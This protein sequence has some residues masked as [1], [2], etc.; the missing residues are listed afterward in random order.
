MVMA[1]CAVRRG[2]VP[3]AG[4]AVPRAV[5]DVVLLFRPR[6]SY[7]NFMIINI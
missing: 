1:F 5:C 4:G 6:K 7:D 3:D 2:V